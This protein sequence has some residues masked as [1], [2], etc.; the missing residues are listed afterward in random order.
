MV[1][2]TLPDM[3]DSHGSDYW[4]NNE[5]LELDFD[6]FLPTA[7]LP[8]DATSFNHA[9]NFTPPD[10]TRR[11]NTPSSSDTLSSDTLLEGIQT[12]YSNSR[13]RRQTSERSSDILVR[14]P[15]TRK[16][17]APHKTAKI[18]EKGACFLCRTMKKEVNFVY[19]Q[20][21]YFQIFVSIPTNPS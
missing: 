20:M 7:L 2:V 1:G 19:K 13:K 6:S 4:N 11:D 17:R 21:L 14:T 16:L 12:P 9:A 18:R 10:D 3:A 15:K 8:C 5:W